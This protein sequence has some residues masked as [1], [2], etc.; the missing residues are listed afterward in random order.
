MGKAIL[1]YIYFVGFLSTAVACD[2][3]D[4]GPYGGRGI[5]HGVAAALWPLWV[6]IILT[7]NAVEA[8]LRLEGKRHG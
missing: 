2:K 4:P 5:A 6:P 7:E 8:G 1:M 3:V